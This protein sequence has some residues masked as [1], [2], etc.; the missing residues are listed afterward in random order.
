M[1]DGHE[2]AEEVLGLW[3]DGIAEGAWRVTALS[4][5]EREEVAAE[6][7]KL[8]EI[9]REGAFGLSAV[10][11]GRRLHEEWLARTDRE[12]ARLERLIA[13]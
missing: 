12:I 2:D 10:V 6:L 1:D 8:R 7:K 9:R 5:A 3:R 11:G 4:V 13:Q